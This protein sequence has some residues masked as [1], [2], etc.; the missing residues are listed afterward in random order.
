MNKELENARK[1]QDNLRKTVAKS[2]V[3]FVPGSGLFNMLYDEIQKQQFVQRYEEWKQLIEERL[4]KLENK[5]AQDIIDNKQF[6]TALLTATPIMLKT[7]E[8]EKRK[9]LANGVIHALDKD[10]DETQLMIFF[11]LLDRYTIWHFRVLLFFQNPLRNKNARSFY[12]GLHFD[13]AT[14][15]PLDFFKQ[16]YSL[17]EDKND[18]L[19][20]IIHDLEADGLMEEGT[21]ETTN[22]SMTKQDLK[23][24][25][26]NSFGDK[27]LDFILLDGQV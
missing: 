24:T 27:F 18:I 22:I 1:I 21:W 5:T 16:A 13:V 3:S 6:A 12:C 14:V 25:R 15:S 11:S 20:K 19:R 26:T 17:N 10:M 2:L 9:Y 23:G 7:A 4:T 8:T